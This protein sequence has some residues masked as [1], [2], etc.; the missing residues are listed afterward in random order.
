MELKHKT[1][2]Y[3]ALSI[4][5]TNTFYTES[6]LRGGHDESLCSYYYDAGINFLPNKGE[7]SNHLISDRNSYLIFSYSGRKSDVLPAEDGVK[8][9]EPNILYDYNGSENKFNN[10]D[11]RYLLRFGSEGLKLIRIEKANNLDND[12]FVE[13]LSKYLGGKWKF[14]AFL[15]KKCSFAKK[16]YLNK[17]N[18]K[19]I[20]INEEL[21]KKPVT[22][23]ISMYCNPIR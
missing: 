23:K 2:L 15:Y 13:N 10:N 9:K 21:G 19:F 8:A 20:E 6:S 5:Q 14:Y 1:F 3:N 22:I 7:V 4:L 18:Q 11:P 17:F 12:S 16:H